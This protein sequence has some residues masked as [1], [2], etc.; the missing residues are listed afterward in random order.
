MALIRHYNKVNYWFHYED[1]DGYSPSF[2][3]TLALDL[4]FSFLKRK[5]DT[6]IIHQKELRKLM[7]DATCVMYHAYIT[8]KR[9]GGP[10]R[11]FPRPSDWCT[12]MEQLWKSYLHDECYTSE[13]WD[14]FWSTIPTALWEEELPDWRFQISDILMYYIQ[15][16]IEN[17]IDKH[18][19]MEDDEGNYAAYADE[20]F[21]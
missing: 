20:E 9:F 17:M 14:G 21:E 19:L 16:S 3:L 10:Y 8:G 4:F 13:F 11:Y 6:L 1:M 7:C 2:T 12:E 15:P 5:N 18:V